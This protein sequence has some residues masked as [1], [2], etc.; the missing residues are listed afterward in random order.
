VPRECLQSRRAPLAVLPPRRAGDLYGAWSSR[1]CPSRPRQCGSRRARLRERT[2]W[3]EDEMRWAEMAPGAPKENACPTRSRSV[4]AWACSERPRRAAREAPSTRPSLTRRAR[5]R[6]TA[7]A[8]M[9]RRVLFAVVVGGRAADERG[10][11][12]CLWV[13]CR[14]R[15]W[16]TRP[17]APRRDARRDRAHAQLRRLGISAK[18]EGVAIGRTCLGRWT[19]DRRRPPRRARARRA[20]RRLRVDMSYVGRGRR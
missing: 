5:P 17:T 2:G 14:R 11:P 19:R 13:R 6:A 8:S 20:E 16:R 10:P 1:A 15:T 9:A 18:S 12:R 3:E 4:I 7:S